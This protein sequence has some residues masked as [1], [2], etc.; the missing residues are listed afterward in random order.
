MMG[1]RVKS[2]TDKLDRRDVF[3]A[4]ALAAFAA[5][6]AHSP[7]TPSKIALAA[8]TYADA[9]IVEWEKRR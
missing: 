2:I 6:L 8:W 7:G 4:Y 9:M 5:L 1:E 3:E